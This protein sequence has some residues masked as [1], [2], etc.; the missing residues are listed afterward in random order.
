MRRE[1]IFFTITISFI[2]SILLVI[3][4][5]S[6]I[7]KSGQ[8]REKSHL[9]KKYFPIVRMFIQ[10]HRHKGITTQLKKNLEIMNIE[11]VTDESFITALLS[12]SKTQV[13]INRRLNRMY[14]QVL[15]LN[16]INYVYIQN[17]HNSF[18][19]KDN[20][21]RQGNKKYVVNSVFLLI[22][23][24]LIIS[25]LTTI[26]K[27]YPLK[28]LKDK[29]TTMGDEKF[30]FDCC[31][32][33][34]KDEVSLLAL[35]FKNT[36]VKLQTLKESRNIFIRN[37]MHELKTPITKGKF[38]VELDDSKQNS[39]KLKKV[40]N[41]LESLINEFASI[42][43]LISQSTK[44]LQMKHYYLED[45]V[46]EAVDTLMLED[47]ILENKTQ[48]IKLFVHFKLFSIAIKNLIDNAIK[49]SSDNKAIISTNEETIIIQNVGNRLKNELE[50]Y[51]EP[52][53]KDENTKNNSFGLGLYI[54]H[55]ILKANDYVLEYEYEEG[56]NRFKCMKVKEKIDI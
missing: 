23:L 56:I 12:N 36:A 14:T 18:L 19:F 38:L 5:Y 2:I 43:E 46:E 33:T 1:S 9:R 31:D 10:E 24:T 8:K 7:V 15:N 25:F 45:I 34:K 32:T 17:M 51:F 16:D 20:N 41:K 44:T 55:N 54:V 49:Y 42:E 39:E 48:N 28:I 6:F 21:T 47:N 29:V 11:V 27:L 4:S 53:S 35:E 37:I 40:F 50:T 26:R 13:L 52:F 3:I 30:D 22:L